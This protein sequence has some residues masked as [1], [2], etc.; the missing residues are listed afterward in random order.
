MQADRAKP[1]N[2]EDEMY[3]EMTDLK[4]PLKSNQDDLYRPSV[5]RAKLN[6]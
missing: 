4:A 6:G 5:L 3:I 1:R 2:S